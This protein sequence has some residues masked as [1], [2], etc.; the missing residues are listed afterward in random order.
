MSGDNTDQGFGRRTAYTRADF[1]D[2]GTRF[3]RIAASDGLVVGTLGTV[4]QDLDVDF[5]GLL[6]L[7]TQADGATTSYIYVSASTNRRELDCGKAGKQTFYIPSP[8]TFSLPVRK[9]ETWNLVLTHATQVAPAPDVEF[10]WIPLGHHAST[11]RNRA[12][13]APNASHPA[14]IGS[15]QSSLQALREGIA[16]GRLQNRALAGV[17]QTIDQRVEDLSQV[18]G[19][20]IR[21]DRA[22]AAHAGLLQALRQIVCS[23]TPPGARPDNRGDDAA[24]QALIDTLGQVTGH[25]FDPGQRQLLDQAVRAL[26]QINDNDANRHNLS[27]IKHNIDLFLDNLQEVLG[28]AFD[29]NQRRL[30]TRALVRL[31]GDGSQEVS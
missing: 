16:S 31:V 19:D 30:L 3:S 6:E 11:V 4:S 17:Q 24:I 22:P 23:A 29:R 27:L 2:G 25:R 1:T 14:P 5:A 7:F 26:L 12:A 28:L 10:Y 18:L 9:G 15:T 8:G 20:A 21:M 13:A